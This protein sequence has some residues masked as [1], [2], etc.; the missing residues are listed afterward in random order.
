MRSATI[1][2]T[3]AAIVHPFVSSSE[4]ARLG[5]VSSS[6]YGVVAWRGHKKVTREKRG[7]CSLGA[8]G[9]GSAVCCKVRKHPP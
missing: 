7:S 1:T 6:V 5:L 3:T 9:G 4:D 8:G 2:R